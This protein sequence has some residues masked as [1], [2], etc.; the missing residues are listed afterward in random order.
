MNKFLTLIPV[1]ALS[2]GCAANSEIVARTA[3]GNLE[4]RKLEASRYLLDA[5]IPTP[6]GDMTV[7]V[8][9]PN[10]T[11]QVNISDPGAEVVKEIAGLGR[12]A[13]KTAGTIYGLKEGGNAAIGLVSAAAGAVANVANNEEQPDVI[14]SYNSDFSN[15]SD[16]SDNS[17]HTNSGVQDSEVERFNSDNN[18]DSTHTPVVVNQPDPIIVEKSQPTTIDF[19]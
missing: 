2:T 18:S 1:I 14:N 9:N 16:N 15:H 11:P 13:V 6:L 10:S 7:K 4:V 19:Q 3:A 5:V 8:A 17:I 12:D